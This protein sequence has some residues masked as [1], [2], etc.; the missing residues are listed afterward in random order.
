[1]TCRPARRRELGGRYAWLMFTVEDRDR[2]LRFLLELAEDDPAV[3]GAAVT[4]S[5][6]TGEG[7][8]WSDVDLA[9]AIRGRFGAA[10]DRWTM[11]LYQELG[12]LHHWDLRSGSS[13]YRVFL[14]PDWLEVDIAFTPEADFAPRGPS[15]RL[16]FGD[17][18]P[19]APAEPP[20]GDELAGLA[21]HHAL[22]ARVC[23]E[24]GRWWQA[25]HWIS[26]VR[27]QVLALAALRLG[28][29]TAYGKGA[30]LLPAEVTAPLEDA[31]VRSLDEAELWRAL[32]AA[33]T[34]LQAELAR[35]DPGL[36]ARLRRMLTDLAA[37]GARA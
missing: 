5:L 12:A 32:K 6:A 37:P 34:A 18:A 28:H 25:E 3:A 21:W 22:R 19:P 35:A 23:I 13:V 14:L 10:L 16:V 11:R 9:F 15:W 30:H 27:D 1:M 7:D 36:A 4:G 2:V 17:S 29:P 8:R 26:G 31:L 33:T 20:K 24:R